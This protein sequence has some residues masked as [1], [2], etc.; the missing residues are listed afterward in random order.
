MGPLNGFTVIELAGIGPAPM[1]GM[2]LADMG[3]EVI[4]I[5]RANAADPK[6]LKDVSARGKKSVVLN[7]KQPEGVETL[8]RMVENADVLIDPYRPGV[9]EKLG[10]GPDVCL[11]RNPRLVFARMTG[12]GQDGPLARAAGHDINYISLTGAL[13]A[14]GRRDEKPVP[15][16]NL[17]GDMGGGGMLLVNGVLAALLEAANSGKG[18]V[19]DVA[20]VDG[21]AQLMWM[22][23]GFEAVGAW[24]ATQRE[25]NLLDGAAH[26]YDTYECADGRYISLGSIEPQFYALLMQLADLPEAEFG[27]QHDAARWPEMTEKLAAVIKQKT[28]AEWCELMEGTDVCF[29]PVLSFTEAP[30]HPAN[31]AR[32]TYVEVDGVT[33][34][35]PAPRFSRTPSSVAHGPHGL[36]EDT[37]STLSAMGF[38]ESEIQ[39]LRE[40]GTIG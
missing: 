23:H 18:Q 5:E 37:V 25:S 8:L 22:F 1:G 2:M 30:S 28:Q 14:T 32:K 27:N 38:A 3:A 26:F 20:M 39:S 13:F 21:A 15:P 17:V 12:W 36:G 6:Q 33:Q 34:P 16:L 35:A 7:L 10:I 24:D 4:R 31:V 9:C 19:I 11:A 40:A 29:A